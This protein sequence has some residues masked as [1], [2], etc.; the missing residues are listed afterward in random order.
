MDNCPK[1][2]YAERA[3]CEVQSE[4][5]VEG[6]QMYLLVKSKV[7]FNVGSCVGLKVKVHLLYLSLF[8]ELFLLF[9]FGLVLLLPLLHSL[10][11]LHNNT[12]KI[13]NPQQHL[14]VPLLV[15]ISFS[16]TI[17]EWKA[18]CLARPILSHI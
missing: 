17:S 6:H 15:S 4:P 7:C 9:L 12:T 14:K 18:I 10:T 3:P 8:A 13:I 16:L 5:G 1:L 2:G 11:V